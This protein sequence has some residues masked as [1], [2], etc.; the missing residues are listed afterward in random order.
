MHV[1]FAAAGRQ[2]VVENIKLALQGVKHVKEMLQK[3]EEKH[4]HLTDT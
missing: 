4:K 1:H 3:K 2:Y